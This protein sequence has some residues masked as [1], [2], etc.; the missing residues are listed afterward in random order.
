MGFVL[1]E[2]GVSASPDKV[3]AVKEYLAPKSVR[4]LRAFLGLC[5]F[6][7]K[8]VP[9]F[10]QTAEPLT[11][12][13]RKNQEFIWG[14]KQ[15]EA[16][17]SMKNKLCTTPVLAYP[18]F[19]SPFILTTDAFKIA[20]AAILSQVQD[21][22]ERPV[23]YVSR[24]LNTAERAYPASELELLALVWATRYFRCYVHGKKFLVRTDHA[25][26]TYEILQ[27]TTTA[28]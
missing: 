8:L 12:L 1:S 18:D 15:Q 28:S 2:R 25:T 24:Q 26:L 17:Q 10:A 4:D 5:S 9:S 20:I 16:F 21:G 7:R 3:K 6:Y 22:I 14:P 23:A 27:I 19:K 11:T 13:T